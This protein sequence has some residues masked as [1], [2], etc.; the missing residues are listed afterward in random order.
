MVLV[1]PSNIQKLFKV[2][3]NLLWKLIL[4]VSYSL[5]LVNCNKYFE[6]SSICNEILSV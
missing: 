6:E 5:T 4:L 3:V 1:G 2:S